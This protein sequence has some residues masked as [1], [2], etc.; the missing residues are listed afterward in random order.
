MYSTGNTHHELVSEEGLKVASVGILKVEP[1]VPRELP[2][3]LLPLIAD[4]D[5]T[6]GC[7]MNTSMTGMSMLVMW[8]TLMMLPN[9]LPPTALLIC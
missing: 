7:S 5:L 2:A 1:G 9:M 6:E 3:H 8:F 4:S